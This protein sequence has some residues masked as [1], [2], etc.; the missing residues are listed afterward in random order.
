MYPY[1]FLGSHKDARDRQKLHD[2]G[3]THIVALGDNLSEAFAKA[4]KQVSI[5]WLS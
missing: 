2:M 3:I 1:L 4:Q 5:F